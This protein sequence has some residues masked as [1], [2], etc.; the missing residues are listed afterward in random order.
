MGTF[1]KSASTRSEVSEAPDSRSSGGAVV[2]H[3]GAAHTGTGAVRAWCRTQTGALATRGIQTRADG[4]TRPGAPGDDAADRADL[5]GWLRDAGP[6][7]SFYSGAG[8]T[9]PVVDPAVSGIY[10]HLER[11]SR[12]VADAGTGRDLHVQFAIADYAAFLEAVYVRQVVTGPALT[13]DEFGDMVGPEPSWL[14]VVQTL[15]DTF[16]A[17]RVTVYDAEAS[18]PLADRVLADAMARLG[19]TDL[20]TR[21]PRRRPHRYSRRMADLNLSVRPHL[22]SDTERAAFR[23]FL[24]SDLFVAD[25]PAS[26][27]PPG[28]AAEL[29]ARYAEDLRRIRRIVEVR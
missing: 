1:L 9:G 15:V 3:L 16:G 22:R 12:S 25:R 8:G 6:R 4:W 7:G 19:V 5:G 27:F 29:S 10:P 20:A 24:R 11:A 14:P 17:D 21:A 23:G 13:F 18:R 28:R 26:F 2:L